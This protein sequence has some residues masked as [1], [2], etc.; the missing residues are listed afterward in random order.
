MHFNSKDVKQPFISIDTKGIQIRIQTS[1]T[2]GKKY[3][4]G[5]KAQ[6][7]RQG[8]K[9]EERKEKGRRGKDDLLV[10][11]VT[12]INRDSNKFIISY[13]IHS[14]DTQSIPKHFQSLS[15][16]KQSKTLCLLPLSHN[17]HDSYYLYLLMFQFHLY[18]CD[19]IS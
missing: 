14:T 18:S 11:F 1:N 17:S 5:R 8:R 10:V 3:F 13:L 2:I 4:Y 19:K 16:W 6:G 9:S 7:R 12:G 15:V